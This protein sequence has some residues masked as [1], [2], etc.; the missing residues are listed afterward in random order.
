[1]LLPPCGI[2]TDQSYH[3]R[4]GVAT[5]NIVAHNAQQRNQEATSA[6]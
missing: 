6:G 1:M 5:D 3:E 2:L 4:I